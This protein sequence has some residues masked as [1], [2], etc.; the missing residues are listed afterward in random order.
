MACIIN[1]ETG[2]PYCGK[3]RLYQKPFKN[4]EDAE[5]HPEKPL[6]HKCRL[7]TNLPLRNKEDREKI[8]KK[9]EA[10]SFYR[11]LHI[12]GKSAFFTSVRGEKSPLKT[13]EHALE[14]AGELDKKG[15]R[16][17]VVD[18]RTDKVIFRSQ[19]KKDFDKAQKNT[20]K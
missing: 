7:A 13:K 12:I 11:V 16:A 10:K 17:W 4:I 15:L 5:N 2:N 3:E 18:T 19:A 14:E 6:C 8:K 1:P 9:Q 20:N